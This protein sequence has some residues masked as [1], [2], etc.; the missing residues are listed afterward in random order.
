MRKDH[1]IVDLDGTLC[2]NSHRQHL[3]VAKQWDEFHSLLHEDTICEEVVLVIRGLLAVVKDLNVIAVTGRNERYR[4]PT[5]RWMARQKVGA[6]FDDMLMRGDTDYTSDQDLKPRMVEKYFGSK[7]EALDRT[8]LVLDDRSSV[9]TAFRNYG[10][11]VFQVRE[12][13]F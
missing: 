7:E 12:G 2:N 5:V 4:M 8:L 10:F 3:A 6:L 1:L 9:V 13:D 11:K